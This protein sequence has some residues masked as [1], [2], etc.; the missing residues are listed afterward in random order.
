MCLSAHIDYND[1]VEVSISL[2]ISVR[3]YENLWGVNRH[4]YLK[5]FYILF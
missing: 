4:L 2:L 1:A 5:V 3:A